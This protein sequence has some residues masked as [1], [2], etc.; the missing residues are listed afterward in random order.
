MKKLIGSARY[1]VSGVFLIILFLYISPE[2]IYKAIA[3]IDSISL[4]IAIFLTPVFLLARIAKWFALIRQIFNNLSFHSIVFN[5]LWGMTLGLLTP[6]K[7][8]EVGRTWFLGQRSMQT[9]LYLLEKIIEIEVLFALFLLGGVLIKFF[10]N[11]IFISL[12]ILLLL[13]II[14]QNRFVIYGMQWVNKFDFGKSISVE[15]TIKEKFSGIKTGIT[16][17]ATFVVFGIFISQV[18]ILLLGMNVSL[19]IEIICL[20]PI[21]LMGNLIPIS[22]GGIGVRESLAVILLPGQGVPEEVALNSFFIVSIINLFIPAVLG[23]LFHISLGFQKNKKEE[24]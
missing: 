1:I 7:V 5:Y 21:I 4:I 17:L 2:K 19:S 10:P 9:V 16:I 18:C 8:G 11:W 22:I 14:F 20:I 24:K 15:D 23:S 3:E 6:G 12:G 13:A